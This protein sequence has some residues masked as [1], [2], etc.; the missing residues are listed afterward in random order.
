MIRRPPRATRT[1]TLFPYTPL[2]RSDADQHLFITGRGQAGHPGNCFG[3]QQ[4]R[5]AD[6]RAIL[7]PFTEMDIPPCLWSDNHDA[8][9]DELLSHANALTPIGDSPYG[10]LACKGQALPSFKQAKGRGWRDGGATMRWGRLR[11]GK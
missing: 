11:D 9:S 7:V 6:G 10:S 3:T 2:F 1:D 8:G 5:N 4:P